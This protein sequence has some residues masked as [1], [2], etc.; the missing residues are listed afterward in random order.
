MYLQKNMMRSDEKPSNS[1]ELSEENYASEKKYFQELSQHIGQIS[2]QEFFQRY[3]HGLRT[4]LAYTLGEEAQSATLY[5]L[6][7]NT[8]LEKN[9]FFAIL[10]QSYE[11]E[12]SLET[13]NP[14]FQKEMIEQVLHHL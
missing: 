1:I 2:S 7:G 13:T 5:E 8:T 14:A 9:P 6:K 10:T 4:I 3:N 11:Y 12:Y